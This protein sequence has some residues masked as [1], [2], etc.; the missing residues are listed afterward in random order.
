MITSITHN[1]WWCAR[2][3][4]IYEDNDIP[5]IN[6]RCVE[7]LQTNRATTPIQQTEGLWRW[8]LGFGMTP[9]TFLPFN[10]PVICVSIR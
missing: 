6:T 8:G 10:W 9:A 1:I 3:K 7:L 5:A 2:N 4:K